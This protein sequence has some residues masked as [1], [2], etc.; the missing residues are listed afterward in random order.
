MKKAV[1]AGIAPRLLAMKK[2]ED[3]YWCACGKSKNQPFCDGSHLGSEFNPVAFSLAEDKEVAL[4]MCKQT[5]NPPF[6]DGS[7]NKLS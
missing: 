4:C 5:A 6:C 1:V 2:G 3:K 7:H